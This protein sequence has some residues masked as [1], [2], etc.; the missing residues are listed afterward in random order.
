MNPLKKKFSQVQVT[1]IVN[2]LAKRGYTARID[3]ACADIQALAQECY[4]LLYT[5]AEQTQ[6]DSAP[7]G[8]FPETT[9][10]TV[11][12]YDLNQNA[13]NLVIPEFS[14][15]NYYSTI[16]SMRN[17]SRSSITLH[18]ENYHR[19]TYNNMHAHVDIEPTHPYAQRIIDLHTVK[20][21]IEK[22]EDDFKKDMNSFVSGHGNFFKLFEAWPECEAL[23]KDLVPKPVVKQL[24]T[25]PLNEFNALLGIPEEKAA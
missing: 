17:V 2:T 16:K 22:E 12:F 11:R 8:W 3:A 19:T 9:R 21:D 4:E 20:A 6:L 10:V 7:K 1:E 14:Q 25:A 5:N 13:V 24:P 23:L 15:E 18:T